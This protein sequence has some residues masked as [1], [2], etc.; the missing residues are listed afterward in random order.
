[1]NN[2]TI[3]TKE[4]TRKTSSSHFY[5]GIIT[6]TEKPDKKAVIDSIDRYNWG[7]CISYYVTAQTNVFEFSAEVYID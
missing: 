2:F 6:F 1:M 3:I 4:V 5:K 7:G